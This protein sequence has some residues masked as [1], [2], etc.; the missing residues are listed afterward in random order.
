MSVTYKSNLD[1][2]ERLLKKNISTCYNQLGKV[3]VENINKETPV[4]S[5]LLKSSNSF[6]IE[7]DTLYFINPV[8]YA[9][10]QELGTYKMKAN[11]FMRRGI[12]KSVDEFT[13]III[14]GL[15]L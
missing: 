13:R 7:Q 9:I 12:V 10:Y 11:S 2:F 8:L 4:K 6:E 14:E 5:G 15:K 1:K 3:G